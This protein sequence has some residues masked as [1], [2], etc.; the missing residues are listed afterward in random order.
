MARRKNVIAP[1]AKAMDLVAKDQQN[2]QIS[3]QHALA[4]LG[5]NLKEYDLFTYIQ[6]GKN[7]FGLHEWSG[8][9][10]GKVLLAIK[11]KEPHGTFGKALEEI[12][13]EPRQAQRYMNIARRYGK[14]DNLSHLNNS[15]LNLLD[16]FSDPELEK[17]VKGDEVKGLTLDA[18]DQLPATEVRKRLRET[19]KKLQNQKER[20][21]KDIEKMVDELSHLRIKDAGRDPLTKEQIAKNNLQGL[22]IEYTKALAEINTGLRKAYAT[23]VEAERIEN[24]NVQQLSDWLGQFH[25]NEMNTFQKLCEVWTNE[26]DNAGPMKDWR[27]SDLK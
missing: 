1:E 24:I 9:I 17:F 27:I 11:E 23:L 10:G 14:Y 26:I 4:S 20:H 22:T 18:I 7:I 2:K 12:G 13:V 6:M 25:D 3:A 16:D 19:E 5:F 15:K 8:V 21:Q